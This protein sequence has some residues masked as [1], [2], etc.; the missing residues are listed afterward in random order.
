MLYCHRETPSKAVWLG[1]GYI[2]PMIENQL[3]KTKIMLD[4][5]IRFIAISKKTQRD[6]FTDK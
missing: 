1:M 2:T 6:K 5:T 3:D 4:G